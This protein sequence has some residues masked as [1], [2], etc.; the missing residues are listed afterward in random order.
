M[1]STSLSVPLEVAA[2]NQWLLDAARNGTTLIVAPP[3]AGKTRLLGRRIV[4]WD[5][6]RGV[7]QL[8]LD[9]VG[10]L[11]DQL[12]DVIARLPREAQPAFW[13]RIRY[14]DVAGRFGFVQQNPLYYRVGDESFYV[15]SQRF[16]ETIRRIDPSLQSAS[17][18][19]FNAFASVATKVG[20]VLL[21]V[22]EQLPAAFPLLDHP[23]A[24]RP[25][26]ERLARD[27]PE[28][29]EACRWLLTAYQELP[30]REKHQ[31]TMTFRRKAE[32]FVLDPVL[33]AQFCRAPRTVDLTEAVAR[34]WLVLYDFS[35]VTDPERKRFG[36][37]WLFRQAMEFAHRRR[38]G[39]QAPFGVVVDELT[40]L[41]PADARQGDPLG[42]DL[43]E[44]ITRLG[45]NKGL[46]I[47]LSL[48]G[49]DQL[50]ATAQQALAY[51]TAYVLGS[52]PNLDWAMEV[53][54]RFRKWDPQWVRKTETHLSGG[55]GRN[56]LPIVNERDIEFTIE[57]Q[58]YLHAWRQMELP[59]YH[60]YVATPS[61][62]G[63]PPRSLSRISIAGVDPGCHPIPAV[64]EEAARRLAVR[65]GRPVANVLTEIAAHGSIEAE[66]T[67]VQEIAGQ[68]SPRR[69]PAKRQP[70]LG[71]RE[72]G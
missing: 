13:R 21:A 42:E 38:P 49:V 9:P 37:V 25:R 3:G 46:W 69:T 68:A 56:D 40:Y 61:Q 19:G 43:M 63:S 20:M 2:R 70:T 60:F 64:V 55:G 22:G 14:V 44:L 39:R 16:V 31:Q 1:M 6:C 47:T 71:L 35:G 62:E 34:R 23:E 50:S 58:R 59:R 65:D 5:F 33:A 48:Q 72:E 66:A 32:P 57:E 41:L 24:L 27:E 36:L 12:F 7:P 11:R 28:V 53:A 8:V 30:P 17:V 29:A 4:W 67:D 18:L 45:R 54:K 26:L 52:T 10:G 15:A 51:C